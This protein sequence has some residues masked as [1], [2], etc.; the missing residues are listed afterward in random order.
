MAGKE[1]NGAIWQCSAVNPLATVHSP[2]IVLNV[3]CE[4]LLFRGRVKL[5]CDL[6]HSNS[7]VLL[8]KSLLDLQPDRQAEAGLLNTQVRLWTPLDSSAKKL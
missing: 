8:P 5:R 2:Q 6:S 3:L 7:F 1:D 4:Y